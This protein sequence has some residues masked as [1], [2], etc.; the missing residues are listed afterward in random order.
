MKKNKKKK[1]YTHVVS[2]HGSPNKAVLHDGTVVEKQ[3][4]IMF[5]DVEKGWV[6]VRPI[7][8][9]DHFIYKT[10]FEWEGSPSFMCTC[11]SYAVLLDPTALLKVNYGEYPA[12][13]LACYTHALESEHYGLVNA[14]HMTSHVNKK[15]F[16]K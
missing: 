14:K 8:Y 11:G 13:R 12:S 5:K 10:P 1:V 2:R 6:A 4:I 9:Y 7:D 3:E 15:D 16:E